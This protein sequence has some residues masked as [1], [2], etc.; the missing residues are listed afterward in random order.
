MKTRYL[1]FPAEL[2]ADYTTRV[3]VASG[4][5]RAQAQITA[6]VLL[7]ADLRGVESHGIS[8]LF[9]YYSQR[10]RNGIINPHPQVK[11]IAE[12]PATLALDGDNGLGHPTSHQA[13]E[14]CI[15]KAQKTGMAT[16]TVR[17]SNHFGIAGYYAMMALPHEMI[18]VCYTNSRPHIVPTFG[19]TPQ[20]GTN[21][22]AVAVPAGEERPYVLDMA[23][24]IVPLGKVEVYKR[25]GKPLPLGWGVDSNGA[26]TADPEAVLTG[27]GLMPLGGPELMRGYKGY[28]LALMV[29]IF[30][31]VLAGSAFGV[32]TD[33]KLKSG[34]RTGHYFSAMRID[35]FRP[36]TEFK[37]D[38]D[39]LLRQIKNAPK[40]AG[41]ERIYI[42]GE[43]EFEAA[44]HNL[45]HGVPVMAEA[46]A[47]LR[48]DG[49]E[50]GVEFDLEPL[51]EKIVE[52]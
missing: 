30:S 47:G 31:G 5:D 27:G 43:K 23:T 15:A 36:P 6:Q 46:V 51:G 38:M 34:A 18:G 40:A 20:L 21:P 35:A 17:N 39:D 44:E 49:H 24:S 29:D 33:P 37:R 4:V 12:T 8:R 7:S 52:E 26:P 16:V 3:L 50:L 1:L 19:C 9:A 45:T 14:R 28:G 10:L 25:A 11:V 48:R 32:Y 22:I 2:L 41:A 42:P 13:M